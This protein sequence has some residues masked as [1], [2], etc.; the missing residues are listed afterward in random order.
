MIFARRPDRRW[1]AAAGAL[2]L[3]DIVL[4]LPVEDVFDEIARRYGFLWYDALAQKI[5]IALGL[6]FAATL[7]WLTMIRP[8]AKG[9]AA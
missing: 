2:F 8:R 6:A 1:L 5:F 9:A 3:L 7:W 4:H